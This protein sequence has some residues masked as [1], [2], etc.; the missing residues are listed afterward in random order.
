MESCYPVRSFAAAAVAA[1]GSAV[2][3][4]AEAVSGIPVSASADP[5]L[6]RAWFAGSFLP[7][8]WDVPSP[9][10]ALSRDYPCADGWIRLHT[11]A[12]HHRAAALAVLGLPADADAA[13]A[14][15]AV[16]PWKGG[17][18][19]EAVVE[20]GGCAARMLTAE[21]WLSHPQGQAV[22]GEP[23]VG[24]SQRRPANPVSSAGTVQRP[25]RGVRV[26]DLSRVIAG[27]VATRFLAGFGADVL[28]IDPPDWNE[29]ALEPEM[30]I[31]KHCARLD[32]RSPGGAAKIRELITGADIVVHGYRPGALAGLGLD[33]HRLQQLH[34]G[35]VTVAVNA[36]GW[37][38]PW[39]GRRGFDSL[40]Q[41]SSGIADAGMTWAAS[42]TP[43]PLPVQALDHATGYL[44][45]AAAVRAW[46][47]RLDGEVHAAR[48]SLARTAVE[49]QR[50]ADARDPVPPLW[51]TGQPEENT[52]EFA[53]TAEQTRWGPGQRLSPPLVFSPEGN[54][55]TMSWEVPAAPLGSAAPEWA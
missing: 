39:R 41:M 8:G 15:L 48:L 16:R 20:S 5:A 49:L 37:T 47:R 3:E 33:E 32:L 2:A 11:N 6:S 27:P 30:T 21:Q 45:A 50:A 36:Y 24:W 22:A 35:I 18:L 53:M 9:W 46:T 25:L 28:R 29:P 12:P 40:V 7:A 34:P 19:E 13:G 38:G 14:A 43:R 54:S 1:A 23:L 52:P 4:L 10:D 42:D 44:A 31:G 26:L 51:K 55:P 17:E